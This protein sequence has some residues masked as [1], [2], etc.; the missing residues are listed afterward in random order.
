MDAITLP[1][2][3]NDTPPLSALAVMR[4]ANVS[5]VISTHDREVYLVRPLD[6]YRGVRREARTLADLEATKIPT[7]KIRFE[8][9]KQ[10][11]R[12]WIVAGTVGDLRGAPLQFGRRDIQT[13]QAEVRLSPDDD[14]GLAAIHIGIATIVTAH[15]PYVTFLSGQPTD[16]YCTGP[17]QHP[18][19]TRPK[20]PRCKYGDDYPVECES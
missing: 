7:P 10:H 16:C 18:H 1:V 6:I 11:G 20:P 19:Q 13:I 2:L 3:P 12:D 17:R 8:S 4:G 9:V 5:G 14:Y 15:E